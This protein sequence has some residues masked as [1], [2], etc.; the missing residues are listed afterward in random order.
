MTNTNWTNASPLV[1]PSQYASGFVAVR[2][3]G[4]NPT[5]PTQDVFQQVPVATLIGAGAAQMQAYYLGPFPDDTTATAFAV[6]SAITLVNGHLYLNS[7]TGKFRVYSTSLV[8]WADYDASAQ[9]AATASSGSA[10]VAT[11]QAAIAQAAVQGLPYYPYPLNASTAAGGTNVLPKGIT[12]GTVGGTGVTGAT[13]GTYPITVS[14]G[15]FTGVTANLIVASATVATIQIVT[16]GRTT[17]AS[18]VAPTFTKPAGATLPAGTT[19][20]ANIGDLIG[21]GTGQFYL[22]SDSTGSNLLYWQNT[23]TG[24]PVAVPDGAGSQV[25]ISTAKL[26]QA[27]N[28]RRAWQSVDQN[29]NLHA[30]ISQETINH[31]AFEAVQD[32]AAYAV[33]QLVGAVFGATITGRASNQLVDGAGNLV[34]NTSKENLDHPALETLQ[35]TVAN[36]DALIT[37]DYSAVDLLADVNHIIGYGESLMEGDYATPALST[38]T[39]AYAR[40]FTGGVRPSD[41]AAGASP[42]PSTSYTAFAA[43][44]EAAGGRNSS[45]ETPLSGCVDMIA[46]LLLAE[47]GIDLTAAN[48]LKM[49]GSNAAMGGKTQATLAPGT[50]YFTDWQNNVSY[51]SAD[52]VAAGLTYATAAVIINQGVN[53]YNA[54][55]YKEAWK[56]GQI[57]QLAAMTSYAQ[58][59]NGNTRPLPMIMAQTMT[60]LQSGKTDPIIAKAQEELSREQKWMAMFPIHFMTYYTDNIHLTNTSQRWQ[61]GYHGLYLKRW[62]IDKIKL[63]PLSPTRIERLGQSVVLTFPL[64]SGRKLVWDTT[65]NSDPGNYGFT[66]A[67]AYG[68]AMTLAAAPRI[69]G[70]NK[71]VLTPSSGT[72]GFVRCGWIGTAYKGVTCLRDDSPLVF[73][74]SGIN[75]PMYMWAPIFERKVGA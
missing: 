41:N 2:V 20:T 43:M 4:A 12:T 44:V 72:I 67:D 6:T 15:D 48:M 11:A 39:R 59:V 73:D 55:T 75:K 60:H 65:F 46:Q 62:L 8:A 34:K 9:A 7:A 29:N 57:A 3:Q 42:A 68:N 47:N 19:L 38:T 74:A 13:V 69:I 36:H 31:P 26:I 28:G 27:F 17:V 52:A 64:Q 58:G 21:S 16:P 23:G 37:P 40:M 1:V 61:G 53:D 66:I 32:Q 49:L 56:V 25:I 33:A 18:P 35:D 24:A 63:A 10:T 51:G 71:V 14:G 54:G 22:T 45:G 30:Q 5:D 70:A 50:T